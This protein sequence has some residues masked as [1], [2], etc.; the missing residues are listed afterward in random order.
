MSRV[1]TEVSRATDC[2]KLIAMVTQTTRATSW[3][4]ARLAGVSRSTVSQVLN[5]NDERFPQETRDRVTAAAAEL[6][7]RPSRAGRSLV[8][9]VSDIIVVVVPNVT[10]GHHLQDAV[11]GIAN[12][13]AARGL[14]V[15]VRYAGKDPEATLTTVLDLRPT[16]VVD[17]G[18]FTAKERLAI[19]AAGIVALP[20][21][22]MVAEIMDDPN[23]H[24]GRLQARHLLEV[25]GRRIVAA[26]LLDARLDSFGPDRAR[27][28]RD[29]AAAL[30]ADEPAVMHVPLTREGAVAA[31]REVVREN[32]DTPL[33]IC[34]YN[35][36]V[37]IALIAAA[38]ELGLSV[39]GQVAVVGVDRTEIGQ[40]IEPRLTTIAVDLLG[41]LA[42]FLSLT[43]L[44]SNPEV[45]ERA[46]R[47]LRDPSTFVSL[48]RG[49][50]S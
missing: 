35:D 39:P 45:S 47:D 40:L 21:Q 38:R 23:H 20:E 42:T 26:L 33:G 14:S 41:T 16:A 9:G 48:V 17:L 15:V 29:E 24:I 2:G 1:N 12:T 10:F 46:A 34:C 4:V 18:V 44:V 25:P 22:S 31:L 3:D 37:A 13:T 5:G 50:S 28:V 43:G 36:D 11:D 6:S 30:G 7:Y 19:E 32:P 8:S 49:E 27:G